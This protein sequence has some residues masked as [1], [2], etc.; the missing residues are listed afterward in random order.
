MKTMRIL[1][2]GLLVLGGAAAMAGAAGLSLELGAV[3][4][5]FN[6]LGSTQGTGA[7]TN[8]ADLSPDPYLNGS[9]TLSLDKSTNLRLGLMA[10]DMM[11]TISPSF[12]QVARAEPYADLL[13]GA[14]SVRVSFP[15]YYL[16]YDATNDPSY[17]EIKYVLDKVYKGIN[18]ATYYNTTNSF[19]FT[20][21]ESVAYKL[22]LDTTTAFVFSASTEIGVVPSLWIDDVKPQVTVIYGPVQLD[23][24]ESI[25][26]SDQGKNPATTDLKYN[27]RLF[28]DPKL[29]LNFASLGVAGLKAYVAASL[30]TYNVYPN[31]TLAN[32]AVF[33]GSAST[34]TGALAVALG[35]SVTP[36]VS[37][38]F[39]PF[40]AELALKYSNFDDSVSNAAKKD[41]TFDPSLKLS[42]TLAL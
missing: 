16:G 2:L 33:F 1:A 31:S 3:G 25:Y 26:F 11:G 12:I 6:A 15:M 14:L 7:I 10:E 28:T 39:G 42:Y 22:T 35:S 41:P 8:S 18:L 20:N 40:Y 36:G 13:A 19:L 29:T 17:T 30:Y 38:A 21:F 32:D 4:Y 23:V 9:Y 34:G 5:D 27:V 24:K 37:Y